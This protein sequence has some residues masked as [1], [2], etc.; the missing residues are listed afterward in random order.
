MCSNILERFVILVS[1]ATVCFL[2]S[3]AEGWDAVGLDCKTKVE[4]KASIQDFKRLKGCEFQW[5][6]VVSASQ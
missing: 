1:S 2:V 6:L 5:I 4:Y 3:H